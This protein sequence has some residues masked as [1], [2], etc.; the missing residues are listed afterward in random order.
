MILKWAVRQPPPTPAGILYR[1]SKI[2][3]DESYLKTSQKSCQFPFRRWRLL[4][5]GSKEVGFFRLKDGTDYVNR[6]IE[7]NPIIP[8]ALIGSSLGNFLKREFPDLAVEISEEGGVSLRL[9][10]NQPLGPVAS[11]VAFA[12]KQLL[13]QKREEPKIEGF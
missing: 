11:M 2:I 9:G 10:P 6:E 1:R 8:V 7:F 4:R 3:T 5:S 12:Y 13:K